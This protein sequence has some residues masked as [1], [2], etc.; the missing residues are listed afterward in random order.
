MIAVA[1]PL[2]SKTAAICSEPMFVGPIG[3]VVVV[4]RSGQSGGGQQVGEP[5]VILEG[6]DDLGFQAC[7]CSLK[8]RNFFRNAFSARSLSFSRRSLSSSDSGPAEVDPLGRPLGLGLSASSPPW[9]H[10]RTHA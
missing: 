6:G 1:G 10:V 9:R 2:A 5:V 7:P 3:P 4:R 8:S